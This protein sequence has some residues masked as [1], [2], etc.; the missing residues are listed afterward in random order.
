M[1]TN[2][3]RKWKFLASTG[4]L[5]IFVSLVPGAESRAVFDESRA[6]HIRAD[7]IE[8]SVLV[9]GTHLIHMGALTDQ[10][11]ETAVTSAGESA[12]GNIYYKSEFSGHSWYLLDGT[13]ALSDIKKDEKAVDKSVIESLYMTHYT[14]ADGI[15]YDLRTG[16]A[17]SIFDI[18]DPYDF[19]E[20]PELRVLADRYSNLLESG[21]T[22]G[23][24]ELLR[25]F[26][27]T[28][29]GEEEVKEGNRASEML[30][31]SYI[32][33]LS[34]GGDIKDQKEALYSVMEKADKERRGKVLQ[35][36]QNLLKGVGEAAASMQGQDEISGIIQECL[37]DMEISISDKQ[38][39]EK[40]SVVL[41]RAEKELALEV[42]EAAENEDD[43]A[44]AESL[45]KFACLMALTEGSFQNQQELLDFLKDT[46]IPL[47]VKCYEENRD[48]VTEEQL[49][50]FRE[51]KDNLE[52]GD[53]KDTQETPK[54]EKFKELE[55]SAA[56]SIEEGEAGLTALDADIEA[57]SVMGTIWPEETRE[58]LETVY[59][60]VQKAGG[61]ESLTSPVDGEEVSDNYKSRL[62]R[63]GEILEQ[64]RDSL[65]QESR[66]KEML[67]ILDTAGGIKLDGKNPEKDASG[68]L[69]L[70][71]YNGQARAVETDTGTQEDEEEGVNNAVGAM[72]EEKALGL[73]Q[74]EE[75]APGFIFKADK[76]IRAGGEATY[77]PADILAEFTHYRYI[78]NRKQKQAI[79]AKGGSFYRFEAF[80]HIVEREGD[81][82]D[83]LPV[84]VRFRKVLYIPAEYVMQEFDCQIYKIAGTDYIVLADKEILKEAEDIAETLSNR[85]ERGR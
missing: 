42:T 58:S 29:T 25:E 26:F 20:I 16:E 60:G 53:R 7:D 1:E 9:I 77:V 56:E 40:D 23:I 39:D 5:I 54:K 63:I 49:K 67:E 45:K 73:A 44:L 31:H 69:G 12:Q 19:R 37:A 2:R 15:T 81:K 33:L 50:L 72:I 70:A 3:I 38:E 43:G 59:K 55:D 24:T 57:Y 34:E 74:G 21:E 52:A 51:M 71:I 75:G 36:A 14:K 83:E 18:T 65:T 30:Y 68:L 47:A 85:E 46:I 6:V 64:C 35:R 11:Y 4:F 22:G 78:W 82:K 8:D 48:T 10:L 27:E 13:E 17:V 41:S 80:S 61:Q 62:S 28:E 84:D 76:D 79:L 32:R 66:N